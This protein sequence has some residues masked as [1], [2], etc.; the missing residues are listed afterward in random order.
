MLRTTD[1]NLIATNSVVIDKGGTSNKVGNS[2]VDGAKV[3]AKAVK[4]KSQDKNKGKNSAK[5]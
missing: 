3:G 5:I 1:V 2:K 4:S